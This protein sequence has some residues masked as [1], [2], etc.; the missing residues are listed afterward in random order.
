MRSNS[1]FSKPVDNFQRICYNEDTKE[2]GVRIICGT[3]NMSEEIK[4][5]EV[6][7]LEED[8]IAVSR[9]AKNHKI[10]SMP[11]NVDV[12][13]YKKATAFEAL[14]GYLDLCGRGDRVRQ[15]ISRAVEIIESEPI[16]TDRRR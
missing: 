9:R 8:E 16:R 2:K 12:Q 4:N 7:E 6:E 10:T 3:G 1:F 11:G 5:N 13:I 15:I 14:L